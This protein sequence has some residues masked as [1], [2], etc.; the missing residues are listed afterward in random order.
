MKK[1]FVF[2][3]C[4]FVTYALAEES[5][6]RFILSGGAGSQVSWLK[7]A[8]TNIRWSN[9]GDTLDTYKGGLSGIVAL[10]VEANTS[11]KLF[12]RF[13][14]EASAAKIPNLASKAIYQSYGVM[15]EEGYRFT[16]RFYTFA[17]PGIGYALLKHNDSRAQGIAINV[18]GGFGFALTD[19]VNLELMGRL[20]FPVSGKKFKTLGADEN[21]ALPGR[22]DYYARINVRF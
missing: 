9:M 3:T 10:G 13:L 14:L 18:N 8:D 6:Y 15:L 21:Q 2:I 7:N 16:P 17:G 11:Q 1:L 20:S 22:L 4:I 12:T 19:N 5:K